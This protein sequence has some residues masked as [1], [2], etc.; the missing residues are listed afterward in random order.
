MPELRRLERR[1]R[2]RR[3]LAAASVRVHENV[4]YVNLARERSPPLRP[5]RLVGRFPTGLSTAAK[6]AVEM[7]KME[8]NANCGHAFFRPLE[9]RTGIS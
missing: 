2:A 3:G 5:S 7:L 1:G 6:K 8:K 4:R 9:R